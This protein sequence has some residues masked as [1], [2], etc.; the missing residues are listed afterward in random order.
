M[1]D[2]DD[3]HDDDDH[4]DDPSVQADFPT[5]ATTMTSVRVLTRTAAAMFPGYGYHF[6]LRPALT[7]SCNGV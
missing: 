2:D 7:A 4:D 3:D 6:P 5:A 1:N